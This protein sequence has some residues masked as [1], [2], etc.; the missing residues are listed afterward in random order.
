MLQSLS[1]GRCIIIMLKSPYERHKL[2]IL[3]ALLIEDNITHI[4]L[5]TKRVLRGEN[6]LST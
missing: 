1:R 6:Y 5:K 2:I 4:W 3:K